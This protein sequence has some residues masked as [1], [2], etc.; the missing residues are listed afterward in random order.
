M[1]TRPAG[2]TARS[3]P[4]TAGSSSTAPP[5]AASPE[6]GPARG[7]ARA[8]TAYAAELV[9][10]TPARYGPFASL[11]VPA[12]DGALPELAYAL[13][14]PGRAGDILLSNAAGRYLGAP[15]FEPL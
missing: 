6:R 12:V 5:G 7:L 11:P 9:R 15:A 8:A 2:I 4:P 3:S 13:D 10:P 14:D 1:P